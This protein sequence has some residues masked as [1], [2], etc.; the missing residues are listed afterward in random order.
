MFETSK[1]LCHQ[2]LVFWIMKS[3][4][5]CIIL[6]LQVSLCFEFYVIYFMCVNSNGYKCQHWNTPQNTQNLI[7]FTS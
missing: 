1:D 7:S 4:Y 2:N 6:A 5:S 3:S